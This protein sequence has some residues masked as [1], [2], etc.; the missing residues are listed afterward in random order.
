MNWDYDQ[1]IGSWSD[2]TDP[3]LS[4]LL[5]DDLAGSPPAIVVVAE[6][7]PLRDEGVEY[8]GLLEHFGVS[9]EL[10]EAPGMTTASCASV[11]LSKRR[12]ILSTT[13][14]LTCTATWKSTNERPL[15]HARPISR[16]FSRSGGA[17]SWLRRRWIASRMKAHSSRGTFL[18]RPP[19]RQGGL[20]CRPARTSSTTGSSLTARPTYTRWTT[21]PKRLAARIRPHPVRIHR[22][23]R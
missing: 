4:L 3:R 23:G 1:Y 22:S 11:V 8:A 14:P 2:R 7:D 12:S 5:N 9:V 6:C 19:V 21:W 18:K 17:S 15:C 20:L 10:L 16:R 13:W